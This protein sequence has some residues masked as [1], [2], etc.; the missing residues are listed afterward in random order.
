M[1]NNRELLSLCDSFVE[2]K[3]SHVGYRLHVRDEVVKSSVLL[4]ITFYMRIDVGDLAYQI[5][6]ILDFI[7]QVNF[8]L[9]RIATALDEDL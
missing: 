8:K 6:R 4:R 2:A 5:R 1:F 7:D 3:E 9:E